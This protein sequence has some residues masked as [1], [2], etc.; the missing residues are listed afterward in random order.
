[1][2]LLRLLESDP[3]GFFLIFILLAL[4]LTAHEW[5]H[6]ITSL[7]MGDPT[8]KDL[9]R[10]TLNPFRHLDPIGLLMLLIAGFGWA[11]PVPINP[12]RFRNYRLGLFVVSIAGIVVNLIIATALALTLKWLSQN[13][14]GE[15]RSVFRDDLH[16][17]PG[18]LALIAYYAAAINLTLAVFNFLPIPPLD[19]SK[20]LMSLLPKSLHRFFWSLEAN[21][22]YA[23]TAMVLFLTF[24][25]QPIS[26]LIGKFQDLFFGLFGL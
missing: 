22:Y 23:I 26:I 8:A 12:T 20:I 19:G 1:M 7:W 3:L 6:A 11:K 9:G 2:G 18:T 4:S 24:L 14:P 25:R 13:Y 21:P 5:G 17:L 16:S 15:V 10:V